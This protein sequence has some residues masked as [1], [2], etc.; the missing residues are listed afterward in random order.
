MDHD[1]AGGDRQKDDAYIAINTQLVEELPQ[2][3][4]LIAEYFEI[5]LQEFSSVQC[6]TYQRLWNEWLRLE[7]MLS[8]VKDGG[9]SNRNSNE[10]SV[11]FNTT[12]TRRTSTQIKQKQEEQK[13]GENQEK[14]ES[15][16]NSNNNDDIIQEF[17]HHMQAVQECMGSIYSIQKYRQRQQHNSNRS[18]LQTNST[19]SLLSEEDDLL[20]WE[21]ALLQATGAS[22][23]S[24]TGKA[25]G[26][27]GK[28]KH[29]SGVVGRWFFLF[30]FF[31]LPYQMRI[32]ITLN[33]NNY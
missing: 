31:F 25:G 2:F 16:G 11:A 7:I 3:L 23:L 19:S 14:N 33:I 32:V 24:I 1:R 15:K 27:E 8:S 22:T 12:A 18:S 30:L 10:S 6:Q 21:E 28:K 17:Q 5:L 9:G 29:D 4:N 20:T 13:Q 26:G